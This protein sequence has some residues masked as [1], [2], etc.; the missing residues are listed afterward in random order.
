MC[1]ARLLRWRLRRSDDSGSRGSSGSRARDG[2]ATASTREREGGE[3]EGTVALLLH[4]R[5][6]TTPVT[7]PAALLLPFPPR[8][9]VWARP[10]LALQPPP[11]QRA[12]IT[13][14][15]HGHRKQPLSSQQRAKKAVLCRSS[16]PS[17]AAACPSLPPS[18]RPTGTRS[19]PRVSLPP[20]LAPCAVH[21]SAAVHRSS[22]SSCSYSQAV[23]C[24]AHPPLVPA[25]CKCC[26][27]CPPAA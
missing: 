3:E 6:H 27:L 7:H 19:A 16:S 20:L 21:S 25:P 24:N 9:S 12:R 2:A 14:A 4:A 11:P 22:F 10:V 23:K 13:R 1:R 15:T 18:S 26:C 17:T 5:H 8:T